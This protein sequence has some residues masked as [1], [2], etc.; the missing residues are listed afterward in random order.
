MAHSRPSISL[1]RLS[2]EGHASMCR[3]KEAKKSMICLRNQDGQGGPEWRGGR[4]LAGRSLHGVLLCGESQR[5]CW[6]RTHVCEEDR[7]G[8]CVAEGPGRP[9]TEPVSAADGSGREDAGPRQPSGA[10]VE[11]LVPPPAARR[12]A[13]SRAKTLVAGQTDGTPDGGFRL[14]RGAREASCGLGYDDGRGMGCRAEGSW[15]QEEGLRN[16]EVGPCRCIPGML[17][18]W[19]LPCGL[20]T[21]TTGWRQ[22][23]GRRGGA[24]LGSC[25]LWTHQEWCGGPEGQPFRQHCP[26]VNSLQPPNYCGG[27]DRG[28]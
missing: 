28:S 8:R 21:L 5:R 15:E 24:Q 13:V 16:F 20:L 17:V 10:L 26:G 7:S 4:G 27:G 14:W 9:C 2:L 18:L 3:Y 1:S 25:R 12:K 19:P 23:G 6:G 11:G 22:L